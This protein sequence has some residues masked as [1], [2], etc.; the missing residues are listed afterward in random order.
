MSSDGGAV[1]TLVDYFYLEGGCCIVHPESTHV[2]FT[3]G[4]G[5]YNWTDRS[6]YVSVSRDSGSSWTRFNLSDS[7]EGY[8]HALAAGASRVV[9]A[10]GEIEGRGVV[11]RSTDLGRSWQRT[12]DEPP[13]T[14]WS[15]AV[16]PVDD[17]IVYAAADGLYRT[18]DG[19]ETWTCLFNGGWGE[20]RVVRLHPRCPDTV[21]VGGA[22]GV[23][24]STDG[25]ETWSPVNAGLDTLS[26]NWL[27]FADGGRRLLAATQGRSC[28]ALSFPV[29][30]DDRPLSRPAERTVE[31]SP[32]PAR[33][34]FRIDC[35]LRHP[36][37]VRVELRDAAGRRAAVVFDGWMDGGQLRLCYDA[38]A[39]GPGV[40]FLHVVSGGERRRRAVVV[41]R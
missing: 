11:F 41:S 6:C 28:Y 39:L 7:A 19:G 40:Y 1:W 27:E 17:G 25:G 22:A 14:V 18:T 23:V 12:G 38:S 36:G 26:V 33:G 35:D 4:H 37:P 20:F 10:A 34:T 9:Y 8:C 13:G 16:H 29:G 31:V 32:S 30:A 2:I 3:G 24:M 15:L 5:S 21:V